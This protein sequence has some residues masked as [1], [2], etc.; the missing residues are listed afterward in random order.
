MKKVFCCFFKSSSR[1][2]REPPTPSEV[3][4]LFDYDSTNEKLGWFSDY[5]MGHINLDLLV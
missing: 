4:R 2:T 5:R 1:E 3:F